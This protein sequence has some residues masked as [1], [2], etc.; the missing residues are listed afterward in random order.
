MFRNWMIRVMP[1]ALLLAGQTWSQGGIADALAEWQSRNSLP[2]SASFHGVAFGAGA[3]VAVGELGI[4]AR[5]TNGTSWAVQSSG[6]T[7]V[8]NRIAFANG[9][10]VVAGNN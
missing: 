10:F 1:V 9:L 8:L 7:T 4:I 2:T 3:F 6:T 5:S